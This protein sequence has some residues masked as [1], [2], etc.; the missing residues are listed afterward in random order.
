MGTEA[1]SE[2]LNTSDVLRVLS[3]TA[4]DQTRMSVF[5][6]V[7]RKQ[8]SS[9]ESLKR[10]HI[11]HP[12]QHQ[13][14][15]PQLCSFRTLKSLLSQQRP[16]HSV[17]QFH[18]RRKININ[19]FRGTKC[20]LMDALLLLYC[21]SQVDSGCKSFL[22]PLFYVHCPKLKFT[23]DVFNVFILWSNLGVVY[24]TQLFNCLLTL[25]KYQFKHNATPTHFLVYLP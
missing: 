3:E 6:C 11:L 20:L 19:S 10:Q 25:T 21:S 7:L 2:E 14:S 9:F 13:H 1:R 18:Q 22:H 23:T 4:G 24:S 17:H 5:V 8:D 15:L 16:E 12:S